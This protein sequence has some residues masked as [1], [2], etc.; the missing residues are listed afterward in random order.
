MV[1]AVTVTFE[2]G[3]VIGECDRDCDCEWDCEGICDCGYSLLC[4]FPP[5]LRRVIGVGSSGIATHRI[6][7]E[8]PVRV[9]VNR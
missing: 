8:R 7:R 3:P 5:Y 2:L 6:G 1:V 9:L 4:G